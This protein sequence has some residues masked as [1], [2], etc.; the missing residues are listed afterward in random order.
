MAIPDGTANRQPSPPILSRDSHNPPNILGSCFRSKALHPHCRVTTH[1][2]DSPSPPT[3]HTQLGASSQVSAPTAKPS[4]DTPSPNTTTHPSPRIIYDSLKNAQQSHAH[5][6]NRPTHA[7]V[8]QRTL[9]TGPSSQNRRGGTCSENVFIFTWKPGS[10]LASL[11]R[12]G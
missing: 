4:F 1:T 10:L 3:I 12:G 7:T 8:D 11:S 6:Y 5:G 9:H 2:P